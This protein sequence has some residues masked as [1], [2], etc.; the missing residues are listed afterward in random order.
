MEP[1]YLIG[2]PDQPEQQPEPQQAEPEINNGKY[3]GKTAAQWR[4][5]IATTP[6]LSASQ[7][8]EY[9]LCASLAEKDGIWEF[10]ALFTVGGALVPD[11]TFVKTKKGSWVW[12]IG[13]GQ[14]CTWFDPSKALSGTR[15]RANDASKGFCVGAIRARATVASGLGSR[16]TV[17]YYIA[18]AKGPVEIVDD[19]SLGTAYQDR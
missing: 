6:T 5:V 11:A 16:G 17:Y 4:H 9:L 10:P 1:K 19:G 13:R 2:G 8:R 18:Q 7:V 12:R 14:V 3:Q 15:R